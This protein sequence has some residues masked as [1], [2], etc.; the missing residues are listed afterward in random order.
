MQQGSLTYFFFFTLGSVGCNPVVS[1]VLTFVIP[2]T[3]QSFLLCACIGFLLSCSVPNVTIKVSLASYWV[4][5]YTT[6]NIGAVKLW[7]N[8]FTH[9]FGTENFGNL[10]KCSIML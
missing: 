8:H 6:G 4:C 5:Y 3:N 9:V 1:P 10:H 2:F 7:R